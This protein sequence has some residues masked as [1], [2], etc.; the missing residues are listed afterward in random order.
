MLRELCY[1]FSYWEL[2]LYPKAYIQK[3][4]CIRVYLVG[5]KKAA[6]QFYCACMFVN[7]L[8][9]ILN[10]ENFEIDTKKKKENANKLLSQK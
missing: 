9:L 5:P 8:K 2:V 10:G 4:V 7:V 6:R 1:D 3:C